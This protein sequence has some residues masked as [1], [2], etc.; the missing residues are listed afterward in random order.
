MILIREPKKTEYHIVNNLITQAFKVEPEPIA[1]AYFKNPNIYCFVAVNGNIIIGTG[2]LHIIQKSNR[3]MGLIEDVVVDP[4]TQGMGV[5]KKIIE[6]LLQT[7]V[8]LKCYK[9]ILNSTEE[10]AG[11]YTKLDFKKEQLQLTIRH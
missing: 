4:N 8:S 2:T 5:G 10:T 11:F 6:K 9:T 3:K 1:Q 7:S